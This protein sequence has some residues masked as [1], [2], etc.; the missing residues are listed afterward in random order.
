MTDTTDSEEDDRAVGIVGCSVAGPKHENGDLPCQDASKVTKLGNKYYVLAVADGLGS[1][2]LSHIGAEK[3]VSAAVEYISEAITPD[4]NLNEEGL[5]SLF[6]TTFSHVRRELFKEAASQEESDDEFKTT[7]LI[8][9]G[10]PE[11]V[12]GAAVGDGGI[13]YRHDGSVTPLIQREQT[14]NPNATIP[15]QSDHWTS[16]YRFGWKEGASGAAVFSDG[17][18]NIVWKGIDS[19]ENEI[20]NQTFS[21]I[22]KYV[23]DEH[24]EYL[25]EFLTSE[26]KIVES[27]D[28][29]KSLVAGCLLHDDDSSDQPISSK[30]DEPATKTGGNQ[31]KQSEESN[32]KAEVK[33]DEQDSNEND[34]QV[35]K[36]KGNPVEIEGNKN[37]GDPASSSPTTPTRSSVTDILSIKSISKDTIKNSIIVML[38]ILTFVNLAAPSDQTTAQQEF[39]VDGANNDLSVSL[40]PD[41]TNQQLLIGGNAT[42]NSTLRIYEEPGQSPIVETTLS[43]SGPYSTTLSEMDKGVYTATLSYNG[44]DTYDRLVVHNTPKLQLTSPVG[45]NQNS[46]SSTFNISGVTNASEVNLQVLTVANNKIVLDDTINP[47]DG[48]FDY[49]LSGIEPGTYSFDITATHRYG[50]ANRVIENIQVS[51]NKEN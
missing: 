12:G 23:E 40:T 31:S 28:D 6:Q 3:A 36:E 35:S 11:G 34:D 30:S 19:V 47:E 48:T 27:K 16:S 26:E 10:G 44:K 15:V 45:T 20:F 50:S 4:S 1:A 5:R 41:Y 13:V 39:P 8:A 9:V 32:D 33:V 51:Q 2:K 37:T 43:D 22:N 7:L 29:D 21:N 25:K 38:L 46:T 17:L 49:S 18:E 14:E 42:T 24:Q